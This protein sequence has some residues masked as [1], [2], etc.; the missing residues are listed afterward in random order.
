MRILLSHSL[1]IWCHCRLLYT[2]CMYWDINIIC[3][4]VGSRLYLQFTICIS[5]TNF[6]VD[7]FKRMSIFLRTGAF[8]C[9]CVCVCLQIQFVLFVI[10]LFI[11]LT[12]PLQNIDDCTVTITPNILSTGHIFIA[13]EIIWAQNKYFVV[14]FAEVPSSK[15][16]SP[17]KRSNQ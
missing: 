11:Y 4:L 12:I 3:L 6:F 14:I 17:I 2:S 13:K 8:V 10:S 16:K 7:N 1:S 9:V 15:I 5:Q